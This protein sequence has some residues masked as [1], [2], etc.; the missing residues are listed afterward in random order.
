M[1]ASQ[2]PLPE[3]V[4]NQILVVD[5]EPTVR[6]LLSEYLN[7]EGFA[8][9]MAGTGREALEK[10]DL[11]EYDV[12]I[13]DIRMPELNGVQL[14]ENLSEKHPDIATIMITAVANLDTAVQ[15]MKRGASDYITKPFNLG[16]V[17]SSVK[18]AL[19][20]RQTRLADRKTSDELQDLVRQKSA[21]LNSVLQ[22][23]TDHRKM[24]L[25]VLMKALDARG[26]ETQS[27]SQ[28]VQA[29][30]VRLAREF[31]FSDERLV[32]LARGA[33]LHDIGKIGV[34]DSILLKPGKLTPKEWKQMRE[35]PAIGCQ[36]LKEV[37]FLEPV[38]WMVLCHHER[39]DG[40]GY[41]QGLR[42]EEIPLESR[43]F[44]IFDAYDAMTSDRPYHKAMSVE[45]ARR[46]IQDC[47]GTQ[48]DP[49]V[50][51]AFLKVP[52]QDWDRI[53]SHYRD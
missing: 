19:D 14:L 26:H 8:C 34:P 24:T 7:S 53:Q 23:L 5:D 37:K 25:D 50:V 13:T 27:H 48:F 52:Q 42:G 22:D 44:A 31:G 47:A 11:K 29:Y 9:E 39:M 46:I 43:I 32:N 40:Q 51:E 10:L 18:R 30:T 2:G 41:P 12:V 49:K 16:Q 21:Q 33:L 15:T 17:V 20:L 45:A 35:H 4:A 28:R 3:H 1:S 38:A 6:T 36:I